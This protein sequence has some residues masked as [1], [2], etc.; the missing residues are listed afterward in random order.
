M[1]NYGKIF[2]NFDMEKLIEGYEVYKIIEKKRSFIEDEIRIRGATRTENTFVTYGA[3]HILALCSALKEVYPKVSV[4]ELIEKSLSIIARLLEQQNQPAHYSFFRNP[5]IT[6][7][8]L[9]DAR[10]PDFFDPQ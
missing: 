8:L 6:R 2:H 1:K 7:R 10:Q 5:E 4:N 9:K 3:F